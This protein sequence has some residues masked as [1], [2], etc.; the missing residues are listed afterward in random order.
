MRIVNFLG[1][2]STP[3]NCELWNLLTQFVVMGFS[4]ENDAVPILKKK[5]IYLPKDQYVALAALID[6][7]IELDIGCRQGENYCNTF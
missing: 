4:Y 3:E 7:Q 6:I 5:G 2:C 1:I